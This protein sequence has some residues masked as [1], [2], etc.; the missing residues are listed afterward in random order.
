[1]HLIYI[2][3]YNSVAGGSGRRRLSERLLTAAPPSPALPSKEPRRLIML[4][5]YCLCVIL[6]KTR[7][8][9]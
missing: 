4:H 8:V 7:L 9:I 5:V 2:Y 1:M 3:I 6:K